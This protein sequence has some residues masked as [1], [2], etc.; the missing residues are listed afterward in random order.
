V[1]EPEHVELLESPCALIVGTV[2]ADLVPDATRGWG[3]ALEADGARIRVLLAS[4]AERALANLAGEGRIALTATNMVT[5]SSVQVKGRAVA[6]GPVDADD[7]I[8]FD[9]FCAGVVRTIAEIEG[10]SEDLV[11][12]MIPPGIVACTMTVDE[13]FDQ[14]PGPAAGNRLAPVDVR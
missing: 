1:L 10:A 4:N 13:V 7:T 2:D 9:R 14:T 12:R 11:R 5:Y 3:A 8:R 6:I